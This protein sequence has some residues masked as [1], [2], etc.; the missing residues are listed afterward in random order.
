MI[1]GL[2][3]IGTV[4]LVLGIISLPLGLI[5]FVIGRVSS[6]KNIDRL[7]V[8]ICIF[9]GLC[10]LASGAFCSLGGSIG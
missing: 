10:F 8:R 1:S 6:K 9:G 5:C 4:A 7:G 2:F 3:I